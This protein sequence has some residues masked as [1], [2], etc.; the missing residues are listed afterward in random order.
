MPKFSNLSVYLLTGYTPRAAALKERVEKVCK[1]KAAITLI[2]K[3]E[4]LPDTVND[5][6]QIVVLLDLPNIKQPAVKTVRS[7]RKINSQ[8]YIL[9]IHIYTTKLLV[10]PLF[11]AG[12]DG[13][14]TYEPEINQLKKALETVLL[15]EQF[16]PDQINWA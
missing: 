12:L 2:E 3:E 5:D 6:L 9:G 7:V 8:F 13:Y 15:N 4:S 11:A 16:I 14:L 1:D 10:E